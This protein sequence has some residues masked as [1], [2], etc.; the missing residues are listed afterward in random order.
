[1][2]RLAWT[3]AARITDKYQIHLTQPSCWHNPDNLPERKIEQNFSGWHRKF[4]FKSYRPL[5]IK[6]KKVEINKKKSPT[7]R[8]SS[9]IRVKSETRLL[10][11]RPN[12]VNI[13][14]LNLTE[15]ECKWHQK[16]IIEWPHDKTNKMAY[17]PSEDSDQPGHPPSLISVFAVRSVGS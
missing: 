9:K 3:F 2:R 15:V 17:E 16:N 8:P 6:R 7:Y 4:K 10:F 1:M 5:K 11:F 14:A 12:I 13:K